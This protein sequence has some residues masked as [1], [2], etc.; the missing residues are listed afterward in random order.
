MKYYIKGF[1]IK[2]LHITVQNEIHNKG[3]NG[4]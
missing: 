4:K 2:T 1:N 3:M